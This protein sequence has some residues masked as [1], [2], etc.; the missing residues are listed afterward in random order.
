MGVPAPPAGQNVYCTSNGRK[1]GRP[2][3]PADELGQFNGVSS[4][5]LPLQLSA[6]LDCSWEATNALGVPRT[7]G[8]EMVLVDVGR[9]APA[10]VRKQ[11][12]FC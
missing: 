12:A 7:V 4:V 5:Y 2:A 3:P 1:G 6:G 8:Q 11:A 9:M 10:S